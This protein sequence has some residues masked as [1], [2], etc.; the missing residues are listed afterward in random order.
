[1]KVSEGFVTFTKN[2]KYL[3]SYIS[4]NL[5]DDYDI[6]KRI[7]AASSAMGALTNFWE[8]KS[9]DL[10]SKYLIF[11]A[12]PTNLLL[13]GCESWALRTTLR[14]KLDVFLHR[15]ARR[16]MG[17]SMAEVRDKKITNE[18]IRKRFFNIPPIASQI[19]KRQL[20]FIGKAVRNSDD[21]FPT[22]LLTAWCN[23]RRPQGGVLH[24]NKKSIMQ[25]LRYIIPTTDR[26]GS[27]Q[28]WAFHALDQVHWKT[29]LKRLDSPKDPTEDPSNPP[30]PPPP[31][32]TPEQPTPPPPSPTRQRQYDLPPSPPPRRNEHQNVPSPPPRPRSRQSAGGSNYN[33]RG[34]G[35]TRRD[36]LNIMSLQN[37]VTERE[38]KVRY[39]K[40]ARTYHPDKHNPTSTNMTST[41]AE[42]FFK[43]IN[44]AY[45]FLRNN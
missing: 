22:K 44:N 27:L 39:R 33:V 16:I 40:L 41:E 20:T 2:F 13:W 26:T 25:H 28:S 43:L 24:S 34:V 31:R 35:F 3:G 9:I 38:I 12:I 37:E 29:L 42:E 11:L 1:M 18:E 8:N 4:Y 10:H 5:K 7:A 17:V 19:A 23:H 14:K 45:E 15:S 30:S 21:Q 6:H 36:S 32:A